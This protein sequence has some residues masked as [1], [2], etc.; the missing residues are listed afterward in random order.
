MAEPY[1]SEP[2]R[3]TEPRNEGRAEEPACKPDPVRP[4]CGGPGDHLS[5][6]SRAASLF[7]SAVRPTR[8]LGRAALERSLLGLAPGGACRAEPVARSAGELL[9]HRFTLTARSEPH[10]GGLFSVAPSRGRPRLG[11]P[12]TLPFG[13]R[14]FLDRPEDRPRP[15]GRLLRTRAYRRGLQRGPLSL[16]TDA[17]ADAGANRRRP[18]SPDGQPHDCAHVGCAPTRS[19]RTAP[20]RRRPRN[21]AGADGQP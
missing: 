3:A 6:R 1:R 10:A 2:R 5:Q 14:T 4:P 9:P 15:P 13:V 7:T 20:S 18:R 16:R 19:V 12:S 8:E 17:G 11:L 21:R